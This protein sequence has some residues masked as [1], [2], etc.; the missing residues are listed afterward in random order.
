ME[1][2]TDLLGNLKESLIEMNY[3][4]MKQINKSVAAL[5]NFDK[6][7]AEEVNRGEKR[8]NAI[9]LKIDK[10]CERI[11]ALQAPVAKDLRFVFAT[12]KINSNL[13][14]IGD[15][16]ESLAKVV[17][18]AEHPFPSD[19]LQQLRFE[20][21]GDTLLSILTDI[22]VAYAQENSDIARSV[23]SQDT[24][25]N[26]INKAAFKIITQYCKEHPDNIEQALHLL[27]CIRKLE[28][29]G[30]HS[31]NIAE[32]IVFYVEAEVLKHEKKKKLED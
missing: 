2:L 27:T 3:L 4:V 19:L 28:R 30:D 22:S 26:E 1:H 29:A 20:Q 7:L 31:T 8:V 18:D 23:F 13:E 15:Y 16:A 5:N 25:L 32:E 12:F 6:V 24:K 21:M 10:E 11:I 14:R 9:E 17:I